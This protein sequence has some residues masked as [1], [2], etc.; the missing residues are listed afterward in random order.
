[1]VGPVWNGDVETI[2]VCGLHHAD[3]LDGAARQFTDGKEP[4]AHNAAGALDDARKL[5]TADRLLNGRA[6][7]SCGV[8]DSL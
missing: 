3:A 1:M 5:K 2:A 7:K 8:C 4:L 6:G